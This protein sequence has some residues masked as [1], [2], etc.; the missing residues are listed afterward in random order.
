MVLQIEG[1]GLITI[2][3]IRLGL[4]VLVHELKAMIE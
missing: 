3:S 1:Y 4:V 2:Y